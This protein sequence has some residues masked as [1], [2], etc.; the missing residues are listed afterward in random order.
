MGVLLL[1]VTAAETGRAELFGIYISIQRAVMSTVLTHYELLM[2]WWIYL[3][4]YSANLFVRMLLIGLGL[5]GAYYIFDQTL[6][7]GF[8][9]IP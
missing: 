6:S 4:S 5:W 3:T 1:F 9:N 2:P 7:V 8:L